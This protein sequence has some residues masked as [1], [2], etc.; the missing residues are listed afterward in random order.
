MDTSAIP[1]KIGLS[2]NFIG[3]WGHPP[4]LHLF[5]PQQDRSPKRGPGD[6]LAVHC[7]QLWDTP[8]GKR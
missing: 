8:S 4:D 6:F 3:G 5:S 2:A 1:S 7:R